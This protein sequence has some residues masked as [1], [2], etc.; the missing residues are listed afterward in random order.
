MNIYDK[1]TYILDI[2]IP[3]KNCIFIYFILSVF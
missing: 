3:L 1:N 2:I